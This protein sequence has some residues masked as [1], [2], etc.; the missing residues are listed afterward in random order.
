[1]LRLPLRSI[2]ALFQELQLR[3]LVSWE[4]EKNLGSISWSIAPEIF[5]EICPASLRV[6]FCS[7]VLS[8]RFTPW[9]TWT[10]LSGVHACFLAGVVL[11]QGNTR[12]TVV[13]HHSYV[14][15]H[16]LIVKQ[17]KTNPDVNA[18]IINLKIY[19]R[20]RL[21]NNKLIE[22]LIIINNSNTRR[23]KLWVKMEIMKEFLSYLEE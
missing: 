21:I 16:D 10:E 23:E 7:M 12:Q 14:C 9:T 3:S 8:R 15:R 20:Q 2:I 1:M 4:D 17:M 6:L 18:P 5:L 11:C 13:C 19:F 22:F